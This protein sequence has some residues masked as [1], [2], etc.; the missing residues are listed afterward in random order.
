MS[1]SSSSSSDG[2]P[3]GAPGYPSAAQWARWQAYLQAVQRKIV[4][5]LFGIISCLFLDLFQ[6]L[7]GNDVSLH[8]V[9]FLDGPNFELDID[10]LNVEAVLV[11][12]IGYRA[13]V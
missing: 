5:I 13:Q 6:D 3:P 4:N 12:Q 10:P 8:L 2:T 11:I 1:D 7:L 9:T